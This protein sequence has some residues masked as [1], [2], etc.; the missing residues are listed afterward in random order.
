MRRFEL[1]LPTGE[2]NRIGRVTAARAEYAWYRGETERVRRRPPSG[3]S[4]ATGTRLRGSKASCCSWQLTGAG[5]RRHSCRHRRALSPHALGDWRA[6]S[7]GGSASECR[8]SRRWRSPRVTK[9]RSA[10]RSRSSIDWAPARWLPWFA[11]GCASAARAMCRVARMKPPREPCRPHGP[12]SRSAAAPRAGPHERAARAP[13][14]PL[15]EDNRSP[16]FSR[17]GQARRSFTR[18]GGGGRVC[19]RHRRNGPTPRRL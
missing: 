7:A 8:T 2:L 16:R 18:T 6:A 15:G 9:T 10:N 4:S 19:A 14:A 1:A 3:W 5:A 11:G 12:R 13:A 17:A